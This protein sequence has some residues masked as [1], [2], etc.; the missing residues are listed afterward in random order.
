MNAKLIL[1]KNNLFPKKKLSQN[2]LINQ[3]VLHKITQHI[4]TFQKKTNTLVFEIGP[5]TGVLTEC[6]LKKNIILEIIEYDRDLIPVLCKNFFSAIKSG[7]LKIHNND[8]VIFLKTLYSLKEKFILCGNLPY[9]ISS[10]ILF[11]TANLSTHALGAIYLVQK[12]FA[13]RIISKPYSKLYNALS[14]ILQSTYDILILEKINKNAFWPSPTVE[15]CLILLNKKENFFNNGNDKKKHWVFFVN[16][17]QA[18]FTKRRKKVLNNLKNYSGINTIF[19]NLKINLNARAEELPPEIYQQ[20]Q[21]ELYET[22]YFPN[23]N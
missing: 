13:E 16:L 4:Y 8:A 11:Q 15:S 9:H 14:V 10:P 22:T 5:G 18:A 20:I 7:Q 23:L 12:E 19:K 21:K 17:V 6:L 2:F 3:D 1:D